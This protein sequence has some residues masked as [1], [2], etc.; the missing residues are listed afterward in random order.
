MT[1][2][3]HVLALILAHRHEVRRVEQDVRGHKHRV[4]EKPDGGAV[5]TAFLG[6]VLKLRHARGL[7]EAGQ[8]LQDPSQLGVGWHLRLD[9]ERRAL[10]V[11][12]QRDELCGARDGAAAQ[13]LRVLLNGDRVQ[14]RDEVE[15]VVV[16]LQVDPLFDRPQ[17]VTQVVRVGGRL[18]AGEDARFVRGVVGGCSSVVSHVLAF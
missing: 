14:I 16:V 18:D 10:R 2:K 3:F 6:L 7:T 13:L 15:R 8:A 1:G 12:A 9:E 17:V 11:D 5:G 4:G